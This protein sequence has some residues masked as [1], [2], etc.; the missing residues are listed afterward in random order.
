MS[1]GTGKQLWA[2]YF[3]AR[4]K[5][6]MMGAESDAAAWRHLQSNLELLNSQLRE[7]DEEEVVVGTWKGD[8]STVSGWSSAAAPGEDAPCTIAIQYEG[9][10]GALSCP[11][12][13]FAKTPPLFCTPGA[14]G[15]LRRAGR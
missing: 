11:A 12:V 9:E 4:R 1:L 5:I 15:A 3:F 7:Q 10:G 2:A 6:P 14:R 8:S 13:P